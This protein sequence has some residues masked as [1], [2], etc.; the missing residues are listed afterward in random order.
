MDFQRTRALRCPHHGH[1]ATLGTDRI[2]VIKHFFP[3]VILK[4]ALFSIGECLGGRT[5]RRKRFTSTVVSTFRT[6]RQE[7]QTGVIGVS[8]AVANPCRPDTPVFFFVPDG[9]ST[10]DG[11][12][13][14]NR[15]S[16]DQ[17]NICHSFSFS[18]FL[19]FC[20][21]F[22]RGKN[23]GVDRSR[24]FRRRSILSSGLRRKHGVHSGSKKVCCN[25]FVRINTLTK[26]SAT[27]CESNVPSE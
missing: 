15:L 26:L 23:P 16:P 8:R 4:F 25:I 2:G 10:F 19:S 9:V 21:F 17:K 22:F 1:V 24:E 13:Q 7:Q 27:T 5:P 6:R 11:S 3:R 14:I 20:F 18:F 12:M